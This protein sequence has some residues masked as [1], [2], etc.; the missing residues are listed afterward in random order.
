MRFVWKVREITS[1]LRLHF[2]ASPRTSQT[3]LMYWKHTQC[4]LNCTHSHSQQVHGVFCM[5]DVL[6]ILNGLQH[7]QCCQFPQFSKPKAPPQYRN[8][9]QNNIAI[10]MPVI[11]FRLPFCW[12]SWQPALWPRPSPCLTTTL[13]LRWR[14]YLMPPWPLPTRWQFL[15]TRPLRSITM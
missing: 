9:T 14:R 10:Y 15:T 4:N 13:H 1:L 3:D 6:L 12:P 8:E 2:R 7:V 11:C 5:S